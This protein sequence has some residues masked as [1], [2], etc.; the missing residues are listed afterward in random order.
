MQAL[1]IRN[2]ARDVKREKLP[3]SVLRHLG[4][5]Y[6]ATHE[7]TR[8]RRPVALAAD[9][10]SRPKLLDDERKLVNSR[11]ACSDLRIAGALDSLDASLFDHVAPALDVGGD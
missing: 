6:Q 4:A 1:Q 2:V 5:A 7:E 8:V 3:A 11:S 9:R 10:R